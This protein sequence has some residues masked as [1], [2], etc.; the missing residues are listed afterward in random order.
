MTFQRPY[1][2]VFQCADLT[3]NVVTAAALKAH[4]N[5]VS[6]RD[7]D[8]ILSYGLAAQNIVERT[9]GRLL[10]SRACTLKL[11][12][13]SDDTGVELPGG[14]VNSLTS[15]IVDGATVTG[16]TVYG[17]SPARVF[18]ATSW[19]GVTGTLYPVVISYMAGF[20][21]IP[22]ALV[23]AIKIIVADLYDRRE[24]VTTDQAHVSPFAASE[25]MRLYRIKPL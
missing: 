15:V 2:R 12:G 7:D 24:S 5:V 4:L 25:L 16:C 23:T 11:Q 9:T 8:V 3:T 21:T 6:T 19:P 1:D 17:D 10:T 20:T 13:F 22:T 18:P 14:V